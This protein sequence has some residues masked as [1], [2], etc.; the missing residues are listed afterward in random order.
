MAGRRRTGHL[1]VLRVISIVL[2]LFFSN[3]EAPPAAGQSLPLFGG[4]RDLD[5][6]IVLDQSESM[7]GSVQH[8]ELPSD[9]DG[10]RIIVVREII[11]RLGLDASQNSRHHRVSLIEFGTEVHVAI[12]G[13]EL[14]SDPSTPNAPVVAADLATKGLTCKNMVY[15]DTPGALKRA[16]AQLTRIGAGELL[17]QQIVLL[18]TDGEPDRPNAKLPQLRHEIEAIQA[19]FDDVGKL[20]LHGKPELWVIGVDT[21]GNFWDKTADSRPISDGKFWQKIAGGDRAQRAPTV[22]PA[23]VQLVDTDVGHWLGDPPPQTLVDRYTAKPYLRE[24]L[25]TVHYP[26]ARPPTVL[27]GPSGEEIPVFDGASLGATG[28]YNTFLVSDP[29]PGDYTLNLNNQQA[30]FNVREFGPTVTLNE[31]AGEVARDTQTNLVFTL[32]LSK[33]GSPVDFLPEWPVS[34]TFA[35]TGPDGRVTEVPVHTGDHGRVLGDWLPTQP[36]AYHGELKLTAKDPDGPPFNLFRGADANRFDLTVSQHAP[37]H[38]VLESPNPSQAIWVSPGRGNLD[39]RFRLFEGTTRGVDTLTSVLATPN[40]WLTAQIF[41]GSGVPRGADIPVTV[42]GDTFVLTLPLDF[43]FWRGE[44]WAQP[45]VRSLRLVAHEPLKDGRQL[46]GLR[47]ADGQPAERIGSDPLSLAGFVIR[48]SPVLVV[49]FVVVVLLAMI[50]AVAL[51]LRWHIPRRQ[52]RNED[53]RRGAKIELDIYD[54][55]KSYMGGRR[56]PVTGVYRAKF[57]NV[58]DNIPGPS[59][60]MR[61]VSLDYKRLESPSGRPMAEVIYRYDGQTTPQRH[62]LRASPDG[63]PLKGGAIDWIIALRSTQQRQSP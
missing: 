16:L 3:S 23:M 40:S 55:R 46:A 36:G 48:W 10:R 24:L 12:D 18:I 32:G 31:P 41:D 52:V 33:R 19:K 25:F 57:K 50:I 6:V 54:S 27:T 61:L 21:T 38:L 9:P 58:A 1:R 42:D 4:S 20:G 17:R 49:G 29:G 5:V 63:E 11:H 14:N 34:G 28:F 15:T 37:Y 51:L 56:L 60:A 47:L 7:D 35:I 39:L 22:F 8:H 53:A 30:W 2:A 44:G 62:T 43:S 13:L 59:G 45:I 26:E